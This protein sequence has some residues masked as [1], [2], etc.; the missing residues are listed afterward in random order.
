MKSLTFSPQKLQHRL[1]VFGLMLLCLLLF[2]SFAHAQ[3]LLNRHAEIITGYKVASEEGLTAREAVN[4]AAPIAQDS[5]PGSYLFQLYSKEAFWADND[6]APSTDLWP[7]PT[8]QTAEWMTVFVSENHEEVLL[9]FVDIDGIA[10]SIRMVISEIP[11]DERPPVSIETLPGLPVDFVDNTHALNTAINMGM[12]SYI[13]VARTYPGY[14][15]SYA[16]IPFWF[17]YSEYISE[18][19]H[20]FWEVKLE[21]GE[22]NEQYNRYEYTKVIALIDAVSGEFITLFTDEGYDG[23]DVSEKSDA[24]TSAAIAIDYINDHQ[25]GTRLLAL[26]TYERHAGMHEH[27]MHRL[28]SKY[29]PTPTQQ[30]YS[31]FPTGLAY[32]WWFVF[33]DQQ[34]EA[35]HLISIYDE[36]VTDHETILVAELDEEDL[37]GI[38]LDDM[39]TVPEHFINSDQVAEI[40][41]TQKLN[42]ILINAPDDLFIEIDY[43][44]A[45]LWWDY[46]DLADSE[47]GVFWVAEVFASYMNVFGTYIYK[48]MVILL[49]GLTGEVIGERVETSTKPTAYLP[50]TI[51]LYQNFPNPFN[52]STQI[53]FELPEH[54]AVTLQVFDLTGKLVANLVDNMLPAGMHQVTFVSDGLASGIYMYRLHAAGQTVTQKMTLIK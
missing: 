6:Q 15:I 9:F 34:A 13:D 49:D 1:L 52:P 8:G 31:A 25:A 18:G 43:E 54:T 40:I 10:E 22:W 35:I 23:P 7:V 17:A 3:Q 36:A 14:E 29:L 12:G 4:Y 28:V 21:F 38:P 41:R 37:P 33:Y 2:S 11:E 46:T 42:D 53:Q 44:L 51:Q 32:E 45:D 24:R 30:G 5:L 26:G 47:T 48:D 20:P 50:V 27:T 39:R 16:A 19:D